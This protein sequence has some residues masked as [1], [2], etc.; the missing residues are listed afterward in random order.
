MQQGLNLEKSYKE[1]KDKRNYSFSKVF[2]TVDVLPDKD[3]MVGQPLEIK[4]Q[5]NTDFCSAYMTTSLSELQEDVLLSPEFQ[6]AK[7]KELEGNYYTWG[8][9]LQDAFKVLVKWGSIPAEV[10][11]YKVGQN[12]R[13]EIANWKNWE[14]MFLLE[15]KAALHKKQAYFQIDGY[16][17]I[18]D[19]IRSA[20][21]INRAEKRGVGTGCVWRGSWNH[22]QNGIVPENY[23]NEGVGHA[24]LFLGQRNINNKLYLTAQ[25]S[26]GQLGDNGLYYFSRKIVNKE[27][28]YGAYTVKDLPQETAQKVCWTPYQKLIWL[29]KKMF[30]D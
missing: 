10:S 11:P 27:F 23:E 2:G 29:L 7:T 15:N 17:D 28:K 9:S 6:F 21:W 24:F 30:N 26:I 5:L 4:N 22:C 8:A 16:G 19:S 3:F 25:N 1:N 18:F 12:T 14:D 20:M 13:D